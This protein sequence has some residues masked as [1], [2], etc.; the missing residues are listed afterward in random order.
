MELFFQ[1]AKKATFKKLFS[2]T[3]LHVSS[4]KHLL[5]G[6]KMKLANLSLAAIVVAGLSTSSFAADTLADAFKEGK[7]SGELRAWYMDRDKDKANSSA[8]IFITGMQLRYNTGTFYGFSLGLTTQTSA[9]PFATSTAKAVFGTGGSNDDIYGSGTQLSEAYVNYTIGKTTAKVGRQFI[10]TPVIGS[11]T[12]RPITQSFEGALVTNTDLPDTSVMIGAITKYQ[13]RTDGAGNVSNFNELNN[14]HDFAYTAMVVNK[15]IPNVELTFQYL[16]FGDDSKGSSATN[17]IQGYED[18]YFEAEYTNKYNNF[19]YG[20]AGNF[21]Y[22]D[23]KHY[24]IATMSG[25]KLSLGYENFK[26]YF[27]YS[28]I[29]DDNGNKG[30]KA[31]LGGGA[32]PNYV[33]GKQVRVGTYSSDTSG[34]SVDANY[35]FKEIGLTTGARYTQLDVAS[36][37]ANNSQTITDIYGSYQF[38]GPLK[39]LE[40][41]LIYT[42][43]GDE[44]VVTAAAGTG[45]GEELWFKANYKF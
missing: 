31:G 26:T 17:R 7:I 27:A 13:D 2:P 18:Y 37:P 23:W 33:K 10:K 36:V 22:T 38:A 11:S 39:G 41:E 29:S 4:I 8:D 15:S 34:F 42:I 30:V 40:A 25:I 19:D 5:Q 28:A 43:L 35:N 45:K 16:T 44:S 9:A 12:S 32:Q 21:L 20:I 3:L 24:D 1:E 6:E 14:D